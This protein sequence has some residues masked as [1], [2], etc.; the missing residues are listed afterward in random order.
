MIETFLKSHGEYHNDRYLKDYTTLKMGG[1][2]KHFVIP[3]T[4]DDLKEIV[5]FL[6]RN[7]LEYKVIGNGSNLVCGSSDYDGVIISL[8]NF[9]SYEINNDELTVGAGVMAPYMA[10]VLA[11]EGY[12][13]LEFAS[14]IPGTFGGLVYMN[15]GAYK[16][17]VSDILRRVLVLKDN[18]LVWMNS[19]ELKFAYRRSI[20]QEHPHWT[21]VKAVI[22]LKRK[23]PEEIINLMADRLE[24]RRNTQPLEYPS[25]GSCFRNP[26]NTPAWKLIDEIG[27]RG[28]ELNGV[29]VSEKHSN[30]IINANNGTAEDYLKIVYDIQKIVKEKYDI[31]MV[32][33]VE[34]FNC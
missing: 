11:R 5:S 27:Y 8:K 6:K 14:G 3:E 34:K 13:A 16:S 26:E 12:S 24:R 1:R 31:K 23:D 19:D 25:A 10:S 28:Y 18:E 33:E 15:A 9:D 32:M 7:S 20:F 4:E 29:K 17:S 22:A 21:I 2:M 30:F